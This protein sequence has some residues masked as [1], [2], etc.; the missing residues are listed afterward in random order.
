MLLS[1]SFVFISFEKNFK[2]IFRDKDYS[3]YERI[4]D[5]SIEEFVEEMMELR[6]RM[7][8]FQLLKAEY[9]EAAKS[10][11]RH[12]SVYWKENT[13]GNTKLTIAAQSA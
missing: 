7:D 1:T 12:E 3:F 2:E 11:K 6:E 4:R 13:S 10:I 5:L 8:P 9:A